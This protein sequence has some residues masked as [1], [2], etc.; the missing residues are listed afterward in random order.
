MVDFSNMEKRYD[1]IVVGAGH[2][3]IEASLAAA[4]MGRRTLLLTMNLDSIGLM[5]C[6]PSI[7]GPAKG[8]LVREI[9][10]LGGEMARA[11]DETFIH[12]RTLNTGK[13]PAVQAPRAQADKAA[14][15]LRM[16]RVLER[17][18]NL[19]LK[20]AMVDELLVEPV[21]VEEMETQGPRPL[22]ES[23]RHRVKGVVTS[24]GTRY[25]AGTVVLTT[26]TSLAGRVIVG[27]AAYTGGRSGEAA[28]VALSG[29]LRE[30]GFQLGRLKTGTPPR[31]D[32]RTIDFSQTEMVEGSPVPLHFGFW[33]EPWVDGQAFPRPNPVYPQGAPT[34]WRPQLPCYLVYTN[35]SV[36]QTIRDN[37]ARAPLFNG[38]IE[39]TGPR[40]CPSIEDK[41]VRFGH[42][43]RHQLFLEPEGWETGEVYVQGANTSLP[44][45]VQEEM[46]RAVPALAGA[47][48]TR[49]GYAIEYDYAPPSHI[50][51]WLETKLVAG[52]FLAGQVNGTSGYEEAAGQGL[53]AG[54]NA[55]LAL[56]GGRPLVLDRSQAYLGVMID[57]LVTRDI[58]EPYRLLTSRA[59]HRLLLRQDNAD[60]RLVPIGHRLGLVSEERYRRTEEKYS[61]VRQEVE[62][63]NSTWLFP[64]VEFNSRLG[65]LGV[66]AISKTTSAGSLLCRPE[67]DYS[68]AVEAAGGG[69]PDPA[70]G[71]QVEIRIRYEPYIRKQELLAERSARMEQLAIPERLDYSQVGGLRNEAREKLARFRPATVGM[72]GRIAGVTPADVAV[73]MVALNK[74][75]RGAGGERRETS[76]LDSAP[77]SPLRDR[78][79]A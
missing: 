71:E 53:L 75:R 3:G 77:P 73:L 44:E 63:L 50:T 52:L 54:I 7:G 15:Q 16:K 65:S 79:G 76:R 41:V 12:V 56:S 8:H 4:R 2:A 25:L 49:V 42:K 18:P 39:G 57:D 14:Y 70:V 20:Q 29:G 60:E 30:L 55:S 47:K 17:E 36:H 1:T 68:L 13:G 10:A 46:L 33:P 5:P 67:V 58:L 74:R 23:Q 24:L 32:A 59:E 61:R 9:D 35:D 22:L 19:D 66:E 38:L 37:L 27:D 11:I 48:L 28:A 31:I 26:G 45:D 69:D 51:A 43:D 62:R 21:A 64:S 72:A 40:Y 34:D 6:N 78:T